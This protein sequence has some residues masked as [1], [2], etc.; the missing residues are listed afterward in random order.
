MHP[1]AEQPR[2]GYILHR[3][4][5]TRNIDASVVAEF[6]AAT[7]I[8]R[9]LDAQGVLIAAGIDPD[10]PNFERFLAGRRLPTHREQ[11]TA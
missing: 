8:E 1:P 2:T 4:G 7:D 11:V 6:D 9:Y 10:A 3:I 5:V